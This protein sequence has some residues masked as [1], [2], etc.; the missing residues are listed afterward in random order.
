M[1]LLLAMHIPDGFLGPGATVVTWLVAA[2]GLGYALWR[3]HVTMG[4]RMVPLMGVTAAG[5]FAGQMVNF[6][7]VGLSTSGHL[8]GGVLAA[9]VLGPW[10]AIVALSTV[11]IVQCFLFADGGVTALGANICN[12]ALIGGGL[13][14]TIYAPLRRI[15]GGGNRGTVLAAVLASWLIIP[16]AALAFVAE[17]AAGGMVSVFPLATWMLFYH[18]LIGL[19]EAAIT[20]LVVSWLVRTHPEMIYDPARPIG[21]IE[22]WGQVA[23]AALVVAVAIAVF[24]APWASEHADGLEKVAENLGFVDLAGE[25]CRWAP[26]PDYQLTSVEAD[27][28]RPALLKNAGV[29][30]SM[31]GLVGT[32]LTFGFGMVVA[33]FARLGSRVASVSSSQP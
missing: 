25:P 10:G 6:P 14:Y 19:G 17:F 29:V 1:T 16:V 33:G 13:G 18:V 9:V 2:C 32:L 23:G 20:G 28:A 3:L 15:V 31:M 11:L 22:R 27:N 4:S 12:M 5:I 26:F 8:M 7:L 21:A 30:T 24:L